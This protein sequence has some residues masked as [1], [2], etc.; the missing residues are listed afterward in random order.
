[1]ASAGSKAEWTVRV[2]EELG[3]YDLN[4]VSLHCGNQSALHIAKN[5]IFHE[6][7]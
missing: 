4:S 2:L 5:L 3:V 7:T 1:M 6:R